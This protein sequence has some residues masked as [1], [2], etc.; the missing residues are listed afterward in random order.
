MVKRRLETASEAATEKCLKSSGVTFHSSRMKF[1]SVEV[2]FISELK[3]NQYS[4]TSLRTT[5]V[6]LTET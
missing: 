1:A 3:A 2:K 4:I 5:E 6:I